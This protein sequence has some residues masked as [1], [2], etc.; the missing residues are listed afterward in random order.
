MAS[1]TEKAVEKYLRQKVLDVG[2]QCY[3]WTSPNRRGVPDRIVIFPPFIS[4]GQGAVWFIEVKKPNEEPTSA[5]K[6][7]MIR[8]AK[9]GQLVGV[10]DSKNGVDQFIAKYHEVKN[11][12]LSEIE[13]NPGDKKQEEQSRILKPGDPGFNLHL[14]S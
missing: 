5:Q 10:I 6:R 1:E 2:G 7:E 9:L 12:I 4:K 8:L 14:N 11:A 13:R 3:K